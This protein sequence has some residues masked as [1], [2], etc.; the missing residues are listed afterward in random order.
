MQAPTFWSVDQVAALLE[1]IKF[2]GAA[3]IALENQVDG[4]TLLGLSD[5]DLRDDLGLSNLQMKRLRK[6]F[7]ARIPGAGS[8]YLPR[9]TAAAASLPGAQTSSLLRSCDGDKLSRSL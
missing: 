4:K 1:S 3:A 2:S 7:E 5:D 9:Q 8:T 6:E